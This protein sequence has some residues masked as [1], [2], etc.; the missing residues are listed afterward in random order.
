[1]PA[2]QK[3]HWNACASRKACC[4]GCS[5]PFSGQ[6]FDGR[7]LV[8]GGAESGHQAG[9]HRRSVEPDGAGAAIAGIAALL[10][11]E[12]A[13]LAQEG[14]QA[15]ARFRLGFEMAMI[16]AEGERAG[17]LV[18]RSS[19]R[20]RSCPRLRLRQLGADLFSE[21]ISQVALVGGAAVHVGEIAVRR[22]PRIDGLP[23]RFGGWRSAS[24][25]SCTGRGVAAVIVSSRSRRAG[26]LVPINSAAERPSL[27]REARRSA[28][29]FT[30]RRARQMDRCAA[31]RRDA[32]RWCGYR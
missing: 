8:P 17:S 18:R 19:V 29:R 2:A 23:Q 4:I 7:H 30:E 25:R 20:C 6:A 12:T 11:A 16:D 13:V 15:L 32:I 14:A 24:N 28:A 27:V 9:M 31:I 3:P 21:V 10:D 5:S 22:N 1:M 26:S